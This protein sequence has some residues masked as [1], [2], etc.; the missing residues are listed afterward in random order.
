VASALQQLQRLGAR[1]G[2][3]DRVDP[4][5]ATQQERQLVQH[6]GLVVDDENV[7]PVAHVRR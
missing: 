7:Q 1:C 5:V 3:V 6:G 4:R 2:G